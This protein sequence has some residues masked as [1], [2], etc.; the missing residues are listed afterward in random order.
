MQFICKKCGDSIDETD[1]AQIAH[2][3]DQR[4]LCLP[5]LL[6]HELEMCIA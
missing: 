2:Y 5:C 6:E 4:D 1:W 3:S